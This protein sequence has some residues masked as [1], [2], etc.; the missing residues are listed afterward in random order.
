MEWLALLIPILVVIALYIF[1]KHKIVWWEPTL[2]IIAGTLI[3]L[4]MKGCGISSLTEDVEYH[5]AYVTQIERDERWEEDITC[6][7]DCNCSEECDS[8]GNNCHEVCQT[9]YYDCPEWHEE[10]YRAVLN[11]GE[12]V[13]LSQSE[14]L[15]YKQIFGQAESFVELNRTNVYNNHDGDR[16]IVKWPG[17]KQTMQYHVYERY[18]ENRVQASDDVFNYPNVDTSDIRLYKL[19][20]YPSIYKKDGLSKQRHVLGT[21]DPKAE[22][23]MEILNGMLGMKKQLT[24]YI[25][26]WVGATEMSGNMQEWYWKGGNKNEFIVCLGVSKQDHTKIDW[27]HVFSW[28]EQ[29]QLKIDVREWV[30]KRKDNF[31]LYDFIDYLYIELDSK[32]VRKNFEDFNYLEIDIPTGWLIALYIV[33]FIF[34]AGIGF[35]AVLNDIDPTD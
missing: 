5:N 17:T 29:F 18:Y 10:I 23:K 27:V 30:N 7:E 25:L 11:T 3:I 31:N 28:T 20:E 21:D 15:K 35:F 19:K 6:S 22:R 8:D 26:I 16:W 33:V 13:S 9:C 32:F 12:S 1:F 24:T 34:S 4:C 14:Y 2:P